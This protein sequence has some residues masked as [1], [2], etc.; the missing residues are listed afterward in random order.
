M[1]NNI[2]PPPDPQTVSRSRIIKLDI[3]RSQPD[4]S[5]EPHKLTHSTRRFQSETF[6]ILFPYNGA[7]NIR[8]RKTEIV[9]VY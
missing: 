5:L 9:R 8:V 4:V 1:N 3:L 6:E 7:A 2:P